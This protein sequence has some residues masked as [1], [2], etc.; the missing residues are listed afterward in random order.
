MPLARIVETCY[1]KLYY[2][3]TN[4]H[5]YLR[6]I[7]RFINYVSNL[8]SL[9]FFLLNSKYFLLL[10]RKMSELWPGYLNLY[11][12]LNSLNDYGRVKAN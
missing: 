7:S 11:L 5:T 3:V 2:E 9:L 10:S 8:C 1:Q 4:G 6:H 12:T